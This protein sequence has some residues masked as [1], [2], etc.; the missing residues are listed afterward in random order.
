MRA[1]QGTEEEGY[2]TAF[3]FFHKYAIRS[4]LWYI[5]VQY[6]MAQFVTLVSPDKTNIEC[7]RAQTL[8]TAHGTQ[9]KRSTNTERLHGLKVF[10]PVNRCASSLPVY[11]RRDWRS[12]SVGARANVCW[13]AG[14][15]RFGPV[16]AVAIVCFF[17]LQDQERSFH[18][19]GW[20]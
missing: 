2:G 10:S 20:Q 8:H 9:L 4:P 14:E 16:P 12:D 17:F 19:T 5:C 7:P 1:E 6:G 11:I 18:R 3:R 15:P 13:L